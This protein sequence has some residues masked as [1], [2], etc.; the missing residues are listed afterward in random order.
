M[1][2]YIQK[3]NFNK[4]EAIYS[5]IS[6]IPEYIE[7]EELLKSF[8]I[9]NTDDNRI[10][11]NNYENIKMFSINTLINNYNLIEFICWDQFK[12]NLNEQYK[13][14]SSEKKK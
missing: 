7:I 4:N 3:E 1:I 2:D 10:N 6:K 11:T 8:F 5:V 14:H 9:E 12:N 13:M